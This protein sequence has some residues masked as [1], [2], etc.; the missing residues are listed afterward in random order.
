MAEELW[1]KLGHAEHLAYEPF[2][3]ASA[4][5]LVDR[6]I[7]IPIS[8]QGKVKHKIMVPTG[9]DKVAIEKIAMHDPKV[10]ELIAGK[11]VSKIIVVPGKMVNLVLV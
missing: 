11:Q 9:A 10:L 1:S 2:P 3:Q 8:I 5:M 6:E 7:E 4:A